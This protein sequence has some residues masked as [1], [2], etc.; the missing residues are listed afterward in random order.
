MRL[1]GFWC[2]EAALILEDHKKA[3]TGYGGRKKAD[4]SLEPDLPSP[5]RARP[6]KAYITSAHKTPS[7]FRVFH[8]KGSRAKICA[9]K[10]NVLCA[11]PSP[12]CVYIRCEADC[13]YLHTRFDRQANHR[14]AIRIA[15]RVC[16]T[17]RLGTA[18]R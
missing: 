14:F 6:R 2:R 18:S 8:L 10:T 4:L 7:I 11:K 9:H 3:Y 12:G 13:R 1:K 17:P 5:H 15:P 16:R